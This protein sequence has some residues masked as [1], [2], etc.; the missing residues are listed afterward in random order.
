MPKSIIYSKRKDC[1]FSILL[2]N[3]TEII[4]KLQQVILELE[5]EKENLQNEHRDKALA[6][7]KRISDLESSVSYLK[8]ERDEIDG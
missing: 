7:Q 5:K 2:Q 6:F 3:K 1:E 4:L 8:K